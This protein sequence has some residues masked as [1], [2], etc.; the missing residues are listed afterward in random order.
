MVHMYNMDRIK[1]KIILNQIFEK[2]DATVKSENLISGSS[3]DLL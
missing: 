2:N 3:Y 1:R